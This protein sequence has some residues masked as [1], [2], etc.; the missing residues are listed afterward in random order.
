MP[1]RSAEQGLAATGDP[2]DPSVTDELLRGLGRA[3]VSSGIV[4]DLLGRALLIGLMVVFVPIGLLYLAAAVLGWV[5]LG[6]LVKDVLGLDAIVG[7]V[8]VAW[9]IAAMVLMFFLFRRV[10][11]W[12]ARRAGALGVATELAFGERPDPA[13]SHL[14]G[15]W[16]DPVVRGS[17]VPEPSPSLA[18]LDA[19]LA[20]SDRA[21]GRES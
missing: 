1:E 20:P 13:A 7:V 18:E 17:S 19:R 5:L 21:P 11:R 16:V 12:L 4:Q 15:R 14:A 8:G 9:W 3:T 2:R 6:T 10:Y